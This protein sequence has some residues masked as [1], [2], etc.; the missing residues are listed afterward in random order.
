VLWA[1]ALLPTGDLAEA[2]RRTAEALVIADESGEPGLRSV[3]HC[4]HASTIDALGEHE[5][6]ARL[7]QVALELG[8]EAS[9]PDAMAWYGARMWLQWSFA[10]QNE[11]A[12]A[13][14][15]Q[16]A[17]AYP[18]MITW[19][20]AVAVELALLGQRQEL[21]DVLATLPTVLPRVPVDIFWVNTHFYFAMAQGF[22]VENREVSKVIYEALLP[23]RFLHV[24]FGI[25]Y[26]GPVEV[27]LAVAARV[28]GDVDVALT[29]HEAASDTIDACGATRARALN[30]YQWAVTLLARDAPGDRQRAKEMLENTLAYCQQRAYLTFERKAQQLLS[31]LRTPSPE[32]RSERR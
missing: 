4:A 2:R 27:G 8:Q 21:T 9:W 13:V 6:A 28:M 23:Y 5:E 7:T 10:G 11:I 20:G 24:S 22:G 1:W 18:Q 12:A 16:A 31:T 19:Q 30:G 3:T 32:R 25:G 15:A 17:A 14:V 26:W 29:H